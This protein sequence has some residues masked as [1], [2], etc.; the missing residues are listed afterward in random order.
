MHNKNQLT[1][2]IN[3]LTVRPKTERIAVTDTNLKTAISDYFV[4]FDSKAESNPEPTGKTLAFEITFNN[5]F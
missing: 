1:P 3:E 4:P 2:Q 5:N